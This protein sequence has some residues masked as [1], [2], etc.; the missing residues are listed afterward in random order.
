MSKSGAPIIELHGHLVRDVYHRVEQYERA[1][2]QR[3]SENTG[4]SSLIVV[5]LFQLA[6][7]FV[8]LFL[9]LY[10]YGTMVGPL[11]GCKDEVTLRFFKE[12]IDL[13]ILGSVFW[14]PS[15]SP[16]QQRIPWHNTT[17]HGKRLSVLIFFKRC[18]LFITHGKSIARVV[19]LGPMPA[20]E[21]QKLV[22]R[23]KAFTSS[24]SIRQQVVTAP[25][26]FRAEGMQRLAFAIAGVILVVTLG[27]LSV[28]YAPQLLNLLHITGSTEEVQKMEEAGNPADDS[29][30]LKQP[31][32]KD[33]LEPAAKEP[34]EYA[35]LTD[36][37]AKHREVLSRDPDN[38]EAKQ[39]LTLLAEQYVALA[40]K[41]A[42]DRL[43]SRATE[44]LARAEQIAPG[45]DS[46]EAARQKIRRAYEAYKSG[47]AQN[48]PVPTATEASPQPQQVA[49]Q[50]NATPRTEKSYGWLIDNEDG[51]ITDMRSG[52][53]GLKHACFERSSWEEASA[54]VASLAHGQCGLTDDSPAGAWR[55]PGKEE[56]S[57]LMEWEK[58]GNFAVVPG[59]SY[60][61]GTPY[62]GDA[63]FAW[64]VDPRSGYLD[65]AHRT[66]DVHHVWPVRKEVR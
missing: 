26:R 17:V 48:S 61:S 55:L 34:E 1:F 37:E 57:R 6:I 13:E 36:L 25:Y 53:V 43:W 12:Q 24:P 2:L 42:D 21:F 4:L 10:R 19:D 7:L 33:P 9:F 5:K 30:A 45:M 14:S 20:E 11:F 59:R 65:Y 63:A 39:G 40:R 58:S 62:A 15:G 49:H 23:L 22:E 38:A 16:I 60:W 27:L 8:R 64:F 32:T 46:I 3:M 50:A 31:E 56:L 18:H 44:L 47:L 66:N 28:L 54:V 51:T 35:F 41:A 52:L 29:A